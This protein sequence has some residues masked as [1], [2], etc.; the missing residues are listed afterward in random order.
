MTS[1]VLTQIVAAACLNLSQPF[2]IKQLCIDY[3]TNC[4]YD[5]NIEECKAK[6]PKWSQMNKSRHSIETQ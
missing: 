5:T 3:W 6:E 2:E 4:A 1:L